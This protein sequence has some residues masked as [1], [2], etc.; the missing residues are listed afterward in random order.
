MD[1]MAMMKQLAPEHQEIIVLR[2]I[3]GFSYDEISQMLKLPRGTVNSRLHRARLELRQRLSA[4]A[5]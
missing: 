2:E 5:V 3:Q 4:Y 1:L